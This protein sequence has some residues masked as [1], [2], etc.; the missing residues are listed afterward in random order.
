MY[1]TEKV[2]FKIGAIVADLELYR[3]VGNPVAQG[4]EPS[5]FIHSIYIFALDFLACLEW[6][7]QST[8][9]LSLDSDNSAEKV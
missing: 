2:E 7:V 5:S 4:F 8:L 3:I 6:Y 1:I 9:P